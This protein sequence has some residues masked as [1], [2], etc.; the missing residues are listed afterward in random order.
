VFP[1]K[2]LFPAPLAGEIAE[3]A[4]VSSEVIKLPLGWM[5]LVRR[6]VVDVFE[7]ALRLYDKA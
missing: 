4:W 3:F 6:R 5:L 2:D 1:L 7:F